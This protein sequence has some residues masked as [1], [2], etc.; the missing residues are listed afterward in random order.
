MNT[1]TTEQE[2][3]IAIDADEIIIWGIGHTAEEARRTAATYLP[4]D[5]WNLP[6]KLE[7]CTEALYQQVRQQGGNIGWSFDYERGL[8]CTRDEAE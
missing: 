4:K 3:W 5:G 6:L 2:Y 1:N 8:H 7:R